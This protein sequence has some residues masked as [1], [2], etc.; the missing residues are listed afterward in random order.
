MTAHLKQAFIRLTSSVDVDQRQFSRRIESDGGIRRSCW[1]IVTTIIVTRWHHGKGRVELQINSMIGFGEWKWRQ[2]QEDHHLEHFR[3]KRLSLWLFLVS[4]DFLLDLD[5]RHG[6]S[7]LLS[8]PPHSSTFSHNC[9]PP[10]PKTSNCI[11]AVLTSDQLPK[12]GISR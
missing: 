2:C 9:K 10:G 12:L 5:D 6:Y 7:T 1:K 4:C 11:D 3:L 8:A